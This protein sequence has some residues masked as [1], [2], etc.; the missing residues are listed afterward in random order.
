MRHS[1]CQ[2]WPETLAVLH[3]LHLMRK[4]IIS[5]TSLRKTL[6]RDRGL[7]RYTCFCQHQMMNGEGVII[8]VCLMLRRSV[9]DVVLSAGCADSHSRL[10]DLHFF[11]TALQCTKSTHPHVHN[12]TRT[13]RIEN[14][15]RSL[16]HASCE[17]RIPTLLLPIQNEG[18][19]VVVEESNNETKEIFSSDAA[20]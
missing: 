11:S 12:C 2:Q 20:E 17:D 1:L 13:K 7:Q 6:Q 16:P 15:S 10:P 3:F 14:Q 4:N 9:C 8:V 18:H 5:M 19:S